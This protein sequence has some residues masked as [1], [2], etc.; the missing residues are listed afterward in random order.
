MGGFPSWSQRTGE[1]MFHLDSLALPSA[2]ESKCG[3]LALDTCVLLDLTRESLC[4]HAVSC[5]SDAQLVVHITKFT[6]LPG[7][8]NPFSSTLDINSYISTVLTSLMRVL[9]AL[10]YIN[11]MIPR[12]A[13]K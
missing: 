2:P 1:A 5:T 12:L 10:D 9:N 4:I 3:P 8:K 7:S 6:G 11:I 13:I